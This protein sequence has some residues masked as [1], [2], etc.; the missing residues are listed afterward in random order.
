[1]GG[2]QM[3]HVELYSALLHGLLLSPFVVRRQQHA[4][5]GESRGGAAVWWPAAYCSMLSLPVGPGQ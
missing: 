1:M 4:C 2:C 5:E 3:L